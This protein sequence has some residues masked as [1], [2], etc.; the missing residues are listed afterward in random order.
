[1]MFGF[2]HTAGDLRVAL[3]TMMV[4]VLPKYNPEVFL[5]QTFKQ[6]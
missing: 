3:Q 1:M 4:Y 5:E 2:C 6:K